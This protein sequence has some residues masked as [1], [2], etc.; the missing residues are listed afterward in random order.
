M[1]I[2]TRCI[3]SISTSS[4]FKKFV[5][6]TFLQVSSSFF[7]WL[8]YFFFFFIN[9]ILWI[10]ICSTLRKNKIV[11]ILRFFWSLFS[12][13]WTEYNLCIQ[14]EYMGKYGPDISLYHCTKVFR[15]FPL[16]TS[17]ENVTKSTGKC[18]FDNIYGRNS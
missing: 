13:I 12:H 6:L 2:A 10:R 5:F 16:R 4:L 3:G 7:V 9:I 1:N 14:F 15:S 8:F 18:G 11:R 17:S